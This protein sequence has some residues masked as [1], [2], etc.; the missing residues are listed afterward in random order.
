MAHIAPIDFSGGNQAGLQVTADRKITYG[1]LADSPIKR[2]IIE[3][4]SDVR[5]D[6]FTE[7]DPITFVDTGGGPKPNQCVIC[8]LFGG[9]VAGK[10]SKLDVTTL[11]T[12]ES[13]WFGGADFA[14]QR[15]GT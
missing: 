1:Y 13:E 5:H 10:V 2:S 11:S 7:G 14:T 4:A 9:L 6:V 15:N 8:M 12:C 3:N